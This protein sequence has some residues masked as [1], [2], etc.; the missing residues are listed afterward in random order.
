MF[1]IYPGFEE[2]PL[3]IEVEW[4]DNTRKVVARLEQWLDSKSAAL[5]CQFVDDDKGEWVIVDKG[6]GLPYTMGRPD[7]LLGKS[8]SFDEQTRVLWEEW[9]WKPAGKEK[10]LSI[11]HRAFCAEDFTVARLLELPE[12]PT[13]RNIALCSSTDNRWVYGI[14]HCNWASFSAP[15]LFTDEITRAQEQ[16]RTQWKDEESDVRFAWE[17]AALDNDQRRD[18]V[19]WP[20]SWQ[21]MERIMKLILTSAFKFM[22]GFRMKSPGISTST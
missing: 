7:K 14:G 22:C 8:H 11:L 13:H 20:A 3:R 9:D 16:L 19:G 18:R 12:L 1:S 21:P 6:S 15:S 17:W 5:I 2:L 10:L 4:R